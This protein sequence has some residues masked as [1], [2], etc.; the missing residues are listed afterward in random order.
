[1]AYEHRGSLYDD[2]CLGYFVVE[3]VP[4]LSPR[5][6]SMSVNTAKMARRKL[7]FNSYDDLWAEAHRLAAAPHVISSGNWTLA[8][9]VQ[10]LALAMHMSIDGS[11]IRAPWLIRSVLRLMSSRFLNK[12][13]SP[14]FKLPARVEQ[15]LVPP[16]SI[17]IEESMQNLRQAIARLAHEPH[18]MPHG[19]LGSLSREQWDQFHFRHAELHLSFHQIES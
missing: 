10:H 14:V 19:A 7:H 4:L 17:G 13:L 8:Q 1:M 5:N 18:R 9:A 2:L 15:Q 6:P 11:N 3:R 12:T 16:A